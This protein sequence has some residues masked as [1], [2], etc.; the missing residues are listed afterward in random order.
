MKTDQPTITDKIFEIIAEGIRVT[1]IL[2]ER[3]SLATTL[4]R[5]NSGYKPWQINRALKRMEKSGYFEGDAKKLRISEKGLSYIQQQEINAIAYE[6]DTKPWDGKWRIVIFD[7]PE[8][9]REIRDTIRATIKEWKFKKLQRS[10]FVTPH[11]CEAYIVQ[12]CDILKAHPFVHLIVAESI[13]TLE[14]VL[15]REYKLKLHRVP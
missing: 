6:A 3:K 13:G 1:G 5:V 2:L 10:V 4:Y 8:D 7:V 15:R 9:H 12:L 11:R 14:S